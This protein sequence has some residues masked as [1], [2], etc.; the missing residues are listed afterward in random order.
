[1]I[2]KFYQL[3]LQHLIYFVFFSPLLVRCNFLALIEVIISIILEFL[4]YTFL[5]HNIYRM[6]FYFL[7][8]NFLCL[9]SQERLNDGFLVSFYFFVY[10]F[11]GFL[12]L[13]AIF[14]FCGR[15]WDECLRSK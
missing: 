3:P 13:Y 7:F 15:L 5:G 12:V 9:D 8:V 11:F 2:T 6:H 1:M 14:S 10:T 4:D